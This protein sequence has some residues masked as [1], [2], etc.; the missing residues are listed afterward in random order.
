MTTPG[1]VTDYDFIEHQMIEDSIAFSCKGLAYDPWNATQVAIHLQDE[2]L[3][4]VEFRQ[5]FKS[6]AAP[7]KEIERLF[8]S[9]R[10]EHGNHPVLEWMFKNATYRKDPAGNIKPDKEM[11]AEKIDG[12][13]ASVMGIGLMNGKQEAAID[14]RAMIA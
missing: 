6:M 14:V 7:S 2:G 10:L 1:N 3:P 4:C 12:V 5:G 11:A 13:V 8:T 9:G